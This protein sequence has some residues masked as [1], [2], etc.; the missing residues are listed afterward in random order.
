MVGD[1]G[2]EHEGTKSRVGT[3]KHNITAG[4]CSVTKAGLWS[5]YLTCLNLIIPHTGTAEPM[6][7]CV[8]EHPIFRS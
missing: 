6:Q 3:V 2:W 8:F 7:G 5:C 4:P 1:F